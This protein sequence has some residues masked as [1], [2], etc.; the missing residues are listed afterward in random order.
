MV[1]LYSQ[2]HA[3]VHREPLDS[4]RIDQPLSAG[5]PVIFHKALSGMHSLVEWAAQLEIDLRQLGLGDYWRN[6]AMVTALTEK[7]WQERVKQAVQSREQHRWWMAIADIEQ[8]PQLQA[9]FVPLLRSEARNPDS[10]PD[11]PPSLR[12]ADYLSLAH[13]GWNDQRLLGRR[14][15]TALRCASSQLRCHVGGWGRQGVPLEERFCNLCGMG[16]ETEHHFLLHCEQHTESRANVY[17]SIDTLVRKT[18]PAFLMS[19]LSDDEKVAV[20][21]GCA[22]YSLLPLRGEHRFQLLSL[23]SLALAQ[24]TLQREQGLELIATLLD[25]E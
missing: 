21:L 18:I 2:Q 3:A 5:S 11:A 23:C 22:N 10:D 16:V 7:Q 24:W 4:D 6:P 25:E 12:R 20:L 17:Q 15:M 19:L 13:G 1:Y 9:V 14:A 8:R